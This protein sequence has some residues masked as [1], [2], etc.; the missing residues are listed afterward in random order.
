MGG[1]G[2]GYGLNAPESHAIVVWTDDCG[3]ATDNVRIS[4]AFHDM[5]M[6][7]PLVV[8]GEFLAVARFD[9]VHD[10]VVAFE[11]FREAEGGLL[12]LAFVEDADSVVSS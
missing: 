5:E 7:F 10:H 9:K 3:Q 1:K 12:V 2:W 6:Q 11:G 4:N 8:G